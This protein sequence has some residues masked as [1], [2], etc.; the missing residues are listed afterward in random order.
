MST[1]MNRERGAKAGLAE[2]PDLCLYLLG[3][4]R[5]ERHGMSIYN[6]RQ[7]L[8]REMAELKVQ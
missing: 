2:S 8:D 3:A 4:S 6:G 7:K 1:D 5:I